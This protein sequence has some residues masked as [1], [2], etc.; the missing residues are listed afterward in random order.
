[1]VERRAGTI[2]GTVAV[3]SMALGERRIGKEA[4]L[5][6]WVRDGNGFDLLEL[7]SHLVFHGIDF[8]WELLI[9]I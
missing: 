8:L 7:S 1:V 2:P 6:Y 5:I 3:G 4:W 9:V